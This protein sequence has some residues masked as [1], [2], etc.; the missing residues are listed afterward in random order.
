MIYCG[1]HSPDERRA[2][3]VACEKL[4][5]AASE[6]GEA[7]AGLCQPSGSDRDDCRDVFISRTT[8]AI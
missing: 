1:A 7:V 4:Q 3:A 5:G 6:G 2:G 8:A